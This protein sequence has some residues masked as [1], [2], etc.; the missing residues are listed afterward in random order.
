MNN[1]K[2]SA[3]L[4]LGA[5]AIGAIVFY[6]GG[7]ITQKAEGRLILR[8]PETK[9]FEIHTEN[10]RIFGFAAEEGTIFKVEADW[11]SEIRGL[12]DLYF[13]EFTVSVEYGSPASPPASDSEYDAVEW[14][15][16][17]KIT[18]TDVKE[19]PDEKPV[20][21]LYPERETE[22]RVKLDYDG[23]L[24][25]T[26]P[27]Y[28][29]GWRVVAQPDGTLSDGRE[30]YRYLYWEGVSEGDFDFSKG[31]CVP[32]E[33]SATFLEKALASLGLNRAEANEFIVYWLPRLEAHPYNLLA[34]QEETYTE[35]AKLEI[36]PT[37]DTVIRVFLAW[38][39]LETPAKIEPQTWETPVRNGFTVV[40]WGGSEVSPK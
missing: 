35:R 2:I 11:D 38:K 13:D 30:E 10:D 36:T 37:P 25:T 29:D 15:R 40:E 19:I 20:I 4:I 14:Y 8:N 33:D 34:F 31:F 17:T 1:K 6:F 12:K 3:V 24:T 5:I 18:V 7:G 21:Y 22:V 9:Y 27:K 32:G 28:E 23:R 26:Y 39:P 16:A